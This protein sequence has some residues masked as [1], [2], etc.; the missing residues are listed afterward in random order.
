LAY[1]N[2]R[3]V[4]AG[5]EEV[6]IVNTA[7]DGVERWAL[8]DVGAGPGIAKGSWQPY[9]TAAG[10]ELLLHEEKFSYQAPTIHRYQLP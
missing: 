2:Q 10:R 7:G 8:V 4:V 6:L 3:V 9:I 1:H 5:T